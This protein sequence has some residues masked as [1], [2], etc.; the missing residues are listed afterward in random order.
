MTALMSEKSR[1]I[2]PVVLIMSLMP[3]TACRSMSSAT[4][5]ASKK[6]APRG[7]SASSRS[8]GMVMTA[9][10]HDAS[11]R[12]PSSA[13]RVRRGPSKANG[14]V[15]TATVRASSS[16]ASDAITPVAPV[17]VP[18]PSPAETKTMSAPCS[19][20]T[21]SSVFSR[22]DW[23]PIS[24]FDPAPKPLVMRAPSCSLCGA[25]HAE[26][27]CRSV[28]MAWNSTPPSPS[29]TR[30]D[31]AL[32]PPP[33]TPITLIRAPLRASSWIS[34]FRLSMSDSAIA[35]C[36]SLRGRAYARPL[37]QDFAQPTA[38]FPLMF[39]LGFQLRRI[40][41]QPCGYAPLRI[42]HLLRPILNPH[43]QAIARLALQDARGDVAK[44][45]EPGRRSGEK[46]AAQQGVLHPHPRQFG[47]HEVEEVFAA[48]LQHLVDEHAGGFAALTIFRRG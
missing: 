23:R 25:A 48:G 1:L 9:S 20:S 13:I 38:S 31:T 6:L 7:T 4:L 42:V 43:R 8:L 21:M 46:H 17:P 24:A 32:Q 2:V 5:K 45:G 10:T 11:P 44:V 22:A 39:G 12:R 3:C 28:S 34:Y 18:P 30:R 36:L 19:S 16:L 37:L 27:A 40:H 33:P 35:I 41:G 29:R 14:L 15:T 47:A 26:S